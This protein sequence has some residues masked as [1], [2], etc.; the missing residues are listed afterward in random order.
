MPV[1]DL[2]KAFDYRWGEGVGNIRQ[3]DAAFGV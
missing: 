2:Q 3:Q 1:H